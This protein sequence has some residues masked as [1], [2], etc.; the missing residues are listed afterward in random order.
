[1]S[2]IDISSKGYWG[3]TFAGGHNSNGNNFFNPLGD[4]KDTLQIRTRGGDDRVAIY[5]NHDGTYNVDINGD[6]YK[7]SREQLEGADI[8][9][10]SGD[11]QIYVD[12]SVDLDLNIH[13]S[14]GDDFAEIH[15]DDVMVRGQGGKDTMRIYGDNATVRD[16]KKSDVQVVGDRADIEVG[17]KSQVGL[18]G[19]NGT[20]DA[21]KKSQVAVVGDN[22]AIEAGKKSH[23]EIAGN[24]NTARAGKKSEIGVNG[25]YND[26][27]AG[28]KSTVDMVGHGNTAQAG[29]KSN[30]SITGDHNTGRTGKK[31]N[32]E[33]SGTDNQV[34]AGRRSNVT[35]VGGDNQV[36]TG[37][38]SNVDTLG[39]NNQVDAGRRST[40]NQTDV[41]RPHHHPAPW[42]PGHHGH[43]VCPLPWNDLGSLMWQDPNL[44]MPHFP[45]PQMSPSFM[46]GFM[47]GLLFSNMGNFDLAAPG[48]PWQF[49]GAPQQPDL[50]WV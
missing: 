5:N 23:I 47:M 9:L 48:N 39:W 37:R 6:S 21:G 34:T 30:V 38:R 45:Q 43:C 17:K 25:D 7:V 46:A 50:V 13:M 24:N 42:A 11:D 15:S 33:V 3:L 27:R 44:F 18:Q 1:M 20:V 35:V 31:S 4:G 8:Y 41:G 28:K 22:N 19:N 29:K 26:V 40:V 16:G 12:P 49:M 36:T 10:G 32:V 14:S 2:T